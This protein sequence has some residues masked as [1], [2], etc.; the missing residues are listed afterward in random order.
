MVVL[1]PVF[2]QK[3]IVHVSVFRLLTESIFILL[4]SQH[5]MSYMTMSHYGVHCMEDIACMF[6][7]HM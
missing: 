2:V 7:N 4:L 1:I 5:G 3:S 6:N